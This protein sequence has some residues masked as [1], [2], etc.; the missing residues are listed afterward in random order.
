MPFTCEV[1]HH[2]TIVAVA[3]ACCFPFHQ[4]KQKGG[5]AATEHTLPAPARAGEAPPPPPPADPMESLRDPSEPERCA[6]GGCTESREFWS[7]KSVTVCVVWFCGFVYIYI[8]QCVWLFG[9]KDAH[10]YIHTNRNRHIYIDVT[11]L[12]TEHGEVLLF[13]SGDLVLP[14]LPKFDIFVL[15]VSDVVGS[16][17]WY[18]KNVFLLWCGG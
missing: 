3:R 5:A 9:G 18:I 14:H 8:H 1:Y 2:H 10:I 6:R 17:A 13:H 12:R 4:P 16:L 7:R 15:V 11:H